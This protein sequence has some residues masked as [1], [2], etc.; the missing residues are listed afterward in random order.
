M[1]R[2]IIKQ[3]HNTLTI[4]LPS[5][6]VRANKVVPTDEIDV[7]EKGNKLIISK[8]LQEGIQRISFDTNF[9]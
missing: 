9:H 2:K 5:K 6:W 4:T 1:R 7:V 8:E 3:G